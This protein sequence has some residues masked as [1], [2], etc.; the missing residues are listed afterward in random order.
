MCVSIKGKHLFLQMNALSLTLQ[1]PQHT[2]ALSSMSTKGEQRAP[3]WMNRER[4]CWGARPGEVC[5]LL[6]LTGL[7]QENSKGVHRAC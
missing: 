6:Q 4:E 7:L 5:P 1:P 3:A 2:P